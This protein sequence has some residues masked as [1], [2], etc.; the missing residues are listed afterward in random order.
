MKK[1]AALPLL[2]AALI[3]ACL[4]FSCV[5]QKK[6]ASGKKELEK[7]DS[8]LVK[9]SDDLKKLDEKRQ[10][11]DD[12][13]EIDSA[14]NSRIKKFIDKT[15]AE[16]DT[17]LGQ[18]TIIV[19]GTEIDKADWDRLR[20]ALSVTRTAEQRINQ[21][22][23]FLEDLINRNMVV[24]LDQDVLFEPGSYS[25]SPAVVSKMTSLFEPAAA[26]IDRFTKKYPDFPLTLV[27]TAKGYADG[28]T[29]GEGSSLYRELKAQL[30]LVGAEPDNKELN[31]QLSRARAK[32]V[33][34]LFEKFAATRS[35]NG[36]YSRNVVYLHE[37]KGETT[38]DPTVKDY[39]LND[40]RRRVVLLFWSIFPD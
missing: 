35:D 21:K 8:Q 23:S 38:P 11:K 25:V 13:N 26:E 36:I 4:L 10:R 28:T 22:I 33:R 1:T 37:G 20:K 16:I 6:A 17:L 2:S 14:A 29:I 34:D 18:N 27:I 32:A 9:H 39:T 40:P 19:R 15:N 3:F 12:Q 30:N 5:P 31:K 7:L 24:K